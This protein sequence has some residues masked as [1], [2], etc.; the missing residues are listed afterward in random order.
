[1]K[2]GS[3][4]P[5]LLL[6]GL[7]VLVLV[8][9]NLY[10]IQPRLALKLPPLPPLPSIDEMPSPPAN[11]QVATT[12]ALIKKMALEKQLVKSAF[13]PRE[14]ARNPFV[15]PAAAAK[16]LQSGDNGFGE[17][18]VAPENH[19]PQVQMVM[20]GECQK[21]ALLD[22]VLVSE[23]DQFRKYRII[24]IT[25]T[26]VTLQGVEKT[27]TLPL[28]A[29][30]TADLTAPEAKP[31]K[32]ADDQAAAPEKQQKAIQKLLR[33]IEPLLKKHELKESQG[34]SN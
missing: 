33:Q 24:L 34:G 30:T 31:K 10:L 2:Q 23:G 6:G 28:G 25:E 1:M 12:M 14:L 19:L 18:A 7:A 11:K 8:L 26:G 9:L 21:T 32:T 20:I 13:V 5:I 3:V 17:P 22:G 29:Y 4:T 16:T 15:D 27:V